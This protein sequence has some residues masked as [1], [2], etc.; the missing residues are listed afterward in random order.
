[1]DENTNQVVIESVGNDNAGANAATNNQMSFDDFL[2]TSGNQAEFDRRVNKAIETAKGKFSDPKVGE[3]QEQLNGY[4]RRE[5]AASAGVT[6][7]F[8]DFVVFEVVKTMGDKSF[9][10]ALKTYLEAHPQYVGGAPS[11][12]HQLNQK[13]NGWGKSQTGGDDSEMSGV[14]AAFR[15]MNPNLKI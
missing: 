3:L 14:E 10:E 2:K 8:R 15:K 6:E 7:A 13:S 9:D 11:A 1:M 5:S 4:I 12:G